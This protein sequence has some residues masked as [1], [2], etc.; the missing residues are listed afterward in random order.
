MLFILDAISKPT[1]ITNLSVGPDVLRA[2]C[3]MHEIHTLVHVLHI[4][5]RMLARRRVVACTPIHK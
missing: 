5:V 4:Q 3:H 2:L 1:R